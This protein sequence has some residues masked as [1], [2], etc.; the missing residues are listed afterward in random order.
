MGIE[1][2]SD[3]YDAAYKKKRSPYRWKP[4]NAPWV[5]LWSTILNEIGP[6]ERI[7]DFGCASGQFAYI[8]LKTGKRFVAGV[9][10]SR[11][12]IVKSRM[13]NPGHGDKFITAD[14]RDPE[15]FEGLDY[16]VAVFCEV[17]EHIGSDLG[18]LKNVP[19]GKRI[20]MTVPSFDSE[21]HVRHFKSMSEA[22]DRYSPLIDIE[23]KIIF[24]RTRRRNRD[25]F[26]LIGRKKP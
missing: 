4:E 23:K 26:I 25:I 7:A 3:Y 24:K 21:A 8:A 13:N 17:L 2:E 5:K 9:D 20:I 18:V 6:D 1:H 11:I 12:R 16:D 14:L 19:A 22:V 10:F 15:T